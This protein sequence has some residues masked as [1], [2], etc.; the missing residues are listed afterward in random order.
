MPR[1]ETRTSM[2]GQPRWAAPDVAR[3]F[4]LLLIAVA[5]A[6]HWLPTGAK[7]PDQY[8]PLD[9]AWVLVRSMLVD[10]REYPLFAVLLGFG[11]AVLT[12]R[13]RQQGRTTQ[14]VASLIRVRGAWLIAFGAV[15][16]LV[17]DGD[18][19]GAYGLLLVVMAP[20]L[21]DPVRHR[22]AAWA[23]GASVFA[24]SMVTMVAASLF[25]GASA[26]EPSTRDPS[27]VEG[28]IDWA[29]N[30][31]LTVLTSMVLPAAL[32]G[33]LIPS[34]RAAVWLR[35]PQG[36]RR[37]L[38]AAAAVLAPLGTAGALAWALGAS[39]LSSPEATPVWALPLH[40][41]S[42]LPGALAWLALI[43]LAAS[44]AGER[45]APLQR[46]GSSSLTAYLLLTPLLWGGLRVAGI[47]GE[48]SQVAGL[49]VG[50][51][52][53]LIVLALAQ[54]RAGRVADDLLRRLVAATLRLVSPSYKKG[55]AP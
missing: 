43:A 52:A 44:F 22:I 24:V 55:S 8:A 53:W 28:L 23:A 9:Q 47:L 16:A 45:A 5:N 46:L 34:T 26:H 4:M 48:Q 36:H 11:C 54:T 29:V 41:A 30:S 37:A 13:L 51:L 25:G 35:E 27:I 14:Q 39:G 17:F 33:A 31:P 40:V 19:L 7:Q 1:T 15:H 2:S 21:A 10:Q 42:G 20:V 6:P 49:L 32:I 3:G 12:S 38:T 50:L 18:V